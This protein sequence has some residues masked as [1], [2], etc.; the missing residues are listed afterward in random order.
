MKNPILLIVGVLAAAALACTGS[1]VSTEE[2]PPVPTEAPDFAD[3][4]SSDTSGWDITTGATYENGQYVITTEEDSIVE[5]G[6]ANRVFNNVTVTVDAIPLSINSNENLEYGL[7]CRLN[8]SNGDGYYAFVTADGFWALA[9]ASG[10]EFFD[11]VDYTSAGAILK[12]AE[13]NTLTLSCIDNTIRLEV[14]GREVGSVQDDEFL[15][16]DIGLAATS[17][18][19]TGD[20]VAF[21]NLIVYEE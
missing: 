19:V 15:N 2:A 12:G 16:G 11:L 17:F 10:N 8:S 9:K 4:F 3:D 20:R 13:Q 18:S 7:A 21:D 5:W 1:G 6:A 14:N